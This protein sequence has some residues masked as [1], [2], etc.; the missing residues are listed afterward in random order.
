[1]RTR[2]PTR[3]SPSP[4]LIEPEGAAGIEADDDAVSIA[5]IRAFDRMPDGCAT[6]RTG[7]GCRRVAAAAAELM[8]DDAARDAADDRAEADRCA[9]AAAVHFERFDDAI[10]GALRNDRPALVDRIRLGIRAAAQQR[11]TGQHDDSDRSKLHFTILR[12]R[13]QSTLMANP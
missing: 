9:A 11:R 1:M 5:G 8:P 7:N 12:T 6:D 3:S 2:S 13:V 4:S 10:L